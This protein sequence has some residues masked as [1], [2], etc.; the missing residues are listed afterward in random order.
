MLL[1]VGMSGMSSTTVEFESNKKFRLLLIATVGFFVATK[2]LVI[3]AGH[4]PI[5][6]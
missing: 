5:D 2:S 4:K 3:A 1:S 6:F